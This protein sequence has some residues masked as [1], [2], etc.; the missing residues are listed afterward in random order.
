MSNNRVGIEVIG[1]GHHL[2]EDTDI[3]ITGDGKGIVLNQA[4]NVRT[5][6]VN[7]Q[8]KD[9]IDYFEKLEK[10]I[11]SIQDDTKLES[12][13]ISFKDKAIQNIHLVQNEKDRNNWKQRSI[14]LFGTLS[15]WITINSALGDPMQPY[16]QKL[17]E[18]MGR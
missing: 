9:E 4:V 18:L 8:F 3:S 14:D 2:I 6:N 15:A 1:G 5:K 16:L 11:N 12:S 10:F 13:N 17:I 7:I